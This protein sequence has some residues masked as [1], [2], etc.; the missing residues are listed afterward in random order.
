MRRTYAVLASVVAALLAITA[1]AWA[2]EEPT[3]QTFTAKVSGSPPINSGTST[4]PGKHSI[5]L[6]M[7][8]EKRSGAEVPVIRRDVMYLGKGLSVVTR[9]VPTCSQVRVQQTFGR[10]CPAGSQIGTGTVRGTVLNN[11]QLLRAKVFAGPG[12]NKLEIYVEGRQG[13]PN[14]EGGNN[15]ATIQTTIEALISRP[16]GSYAKTFGVQIAFDVPPNLQEPL[17]NVFAHITDY[18]VAITK[19]LVLS[20]SCPSTRKWSARL[21][22]TRRDGGAKL[23]GKST[24][25]CRP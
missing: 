14:G 3:I 10:G 21:E 24:Q 15:P 5:T 7:H 23:I 22:S 13:E 1:I 4:R 18:T 2:Q 25:A 6:K 17:R 8:R 12:G 11:V 19:R 16:V 9:G 20:K